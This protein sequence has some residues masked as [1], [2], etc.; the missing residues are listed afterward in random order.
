[1]KYDRLH[2]VLRYDADTGI[3][4]WSVSQN[5]RAQ[6]GSIAGYKRPDGYIQIRIDGKTIL[7]TG[8]AWLYV[9]GYFP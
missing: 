8:S 4:K 5:N 7:L 1:M 2:E 3:F 9:H 6:A